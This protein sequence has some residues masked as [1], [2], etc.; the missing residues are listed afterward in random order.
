MVEV[1]TMP[2]TPMKQILDEAKAKGYGVGAYNVNNME[3][4]QAIM[5]AA[6]QTHS[7]LIIQAS[8]GALEY[9]NFCY[10]KHL[11]LAA[12]EDNPEVPVALHLDH[13][14]T[15]ETVKKAIEIGFTS[16]MIDGSLDY[17]HK[18]KSGSHAPRSFE[19]NI[20]VTREVVDYAHAY[21]V[22]VEGELG[23]LGGIEE[24]TVTDEA[25]LTDPDQVE[26]FVKRTGVDAL[27]IAIGTSHG[28]YKFKHEPKLALD[29]VNEIV[30]RVPKTAL[31]MHGSSS[32]PK[33]LTDAVNTCPAVELKMDKRVILFQGQEYNT[34]CEKDGVRLM[35]D[36]LAKPNMPHTMGVPISQIQDAV[37]RGITKINVDTDGRLGVTATIR[38][39]FARKPAEFDPRKYLGPA[40][41]SLAKIIAEK[42]VAFGTAGH[43]GDYKPKTLADMKAFYAV[44]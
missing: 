44:K 11:M 16:V 29:L 42:M 1:I 36:L 40:R 10:L 4:I 37:K 21:G 7:P 25:N 14:D 8:R 32:V 9:T 23:T 38:Q 34:S 18:T 30:K 19:D 24:D 33:E 15:I 35:A 41:D 6:N 26:E 17:G 39:V 5:K 31:V 28:A 3:Q 43:I 20:R 22:S 2:M 12:V 27:A 13:G